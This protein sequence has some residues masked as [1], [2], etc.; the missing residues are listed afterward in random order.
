[1]NADAH[2]LLRLTETL[3]FYP[4]GGV[5]LS[6]WNFHYIDATKVRVGLNL[7]MGIE[8]RINRDLI[9]GAEFK[10]NWTTQRAYDQALLAA[11]IGY[12]F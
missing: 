12:Y 11:R 8:Q 3:T 2:Y 7:G 1:M 9:V 4:I 5:G 10:Y 6:I